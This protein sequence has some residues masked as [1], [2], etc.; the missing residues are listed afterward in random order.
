VASKNLD[1]EDL[2]RLG[3]KSLLVM[4]EEVWILN[5]HKGWFDADRTF[6]DEIALMVTEL[7]EAVDAFREYG[8]RDVTYVSGDPNSPTPKPEGVASELADLL[9]RLL[10][11]CGRYEIDLELEYE[12][13][14]TYNRT[15]PHRH[16]GKRL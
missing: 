3:P 13:K 16:G 4:R 8:M 6:G 5:H 12:R 14:M 10:D 11:T 2:K 7:G 15:R 9:I 1:L